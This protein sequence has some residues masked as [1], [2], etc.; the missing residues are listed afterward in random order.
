M[1]PT[2]LVVTVV[3]LAMVIAIAIA[4]LKAAGRAWRTLDRR[5]EED[6]RDASRQHD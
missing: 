3:V 4:L 2:S 5:E 6:W 1:T